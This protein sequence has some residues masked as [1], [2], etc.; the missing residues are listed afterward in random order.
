MRLKKVLLF[1]DFS[2]QVY[3]QGN[4]IS[5]YYLCFV[6]AHKFTL[7]SYILY[8]ITSSLSILILHIILRYFLPSTYT[9]PYRFPTDLYTKGDTIVE[10]LATS[11]AV[12]G[13]PWQTPENGYVMRS[14]Q[15]KFPSVYYEPHCMYNELELKRIGKV[16]YVIAPGK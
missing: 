6:S 9:S 10:I 8:R 13:P 5:D 12:L 16:D 14:P 11:G 7:Y 4:S 15:N 3:I 2:R 1:L